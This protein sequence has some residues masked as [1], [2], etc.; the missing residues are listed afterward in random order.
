MNKQ[1]ENRTRQLAI[2][3]ACHHSEYV[4]ERVS[5]VGEMFLRLLQDKM[6]QWRCVIYDVVDQCYPADLKEVDGVV[7]TGSPASVYDEQP[8][9]KT[10]QQK[11]QQVI[12]EGIPLLGVCFGHQLIAQVLGGKVEKATVGWGLGIKPVPFTQTPWMSPWLKPLNL[13]HVHQDQ[14]TRLPEG[15]RCLAGDEFCPYESFAIA[16]RILTVQGHPEFTNHTL[17]VLN[18]DLKTRGVSDSVLKNSASSL[19]K[20]NDGDVFAQWSAEFFAYATEK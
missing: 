15:A 18:E 2:F 19:K 4:R 16:D 9:I 17:E 14:V 8:W 1:Q 3:M 6:P 13:V 11:T 5:G 12:E 7:I 10:L 20:H